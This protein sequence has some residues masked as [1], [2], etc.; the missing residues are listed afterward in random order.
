MAGERDASPIS[1]VDP[2]TRNRSVEE[3]KISTDE[4]VLVI[5]NSSDAALQTS[6]LRAQLMTT[7]SSQCLLTVHVFAS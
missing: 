4:A 2:L 6:S 1:S 3:L 5:L 7:E